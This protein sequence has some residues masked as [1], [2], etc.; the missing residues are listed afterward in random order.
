MEDT[1]ISSMEKERKMRE[2]KEESQKVREVS[3]VVSPK[4]EDQMKEAK[5]VIERISVE[6]LRAI[7]TPS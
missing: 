7:Y 3:P 4:R 2:L 5:E 1:T 6:H